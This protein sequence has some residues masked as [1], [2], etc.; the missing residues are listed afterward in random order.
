MKLFLLCLDTPDFNLA[1]TSKF[2]ISGVVAYPIPINNP[3]I[4]I[5]NTDRPVIQGNRH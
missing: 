4:M 1:R 5:L 2:V 3:I